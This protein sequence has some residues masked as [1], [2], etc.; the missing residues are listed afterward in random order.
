M[1]RR[2]FT[3][4]L[5]LALLSLA[6]LTACTDMPD[7]LKIGVAQPLS[8]NMAPH[9]N[10]LLNGVK[11]AVQELNAEGFKVKGK[12]IKLEI[13]PVDDRSSPEAGKEVAKQL[14]DAGVVAV[15]GHL[16][17]GVS[18][19][20]APIY[21]AKGIPQLAISTNPKYTE[22][23]I[24][25]AFR[26]VANDK[27]QAKAIGSFAISRMGGTRFAVVDDGSTYGKDLAAG[28]AAQLV[29]GKKNI[30]FQESFDDKTV[31]FDSL[32]QHLKEVRVDALI[33]T[34]NDFQVLALL[35]SLKKIGHTQ[36]SIMGGDLLKT[37]AM[38]KAGND[39]LGIYVSSPIVQ[40]SEF[41]TGKVFLAK[42]R[43]AFKTEP[44][45]AGHYTYDAMY[46]IAAAIKKAESAKPADIAAALRQIDSYAPITG[47]LSFDANG[48]QKYGAISIYQLRAE[49]WELQLRSDVW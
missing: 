29:A 38:L 14:V 35:E 49:K 3:N 19:P 28:A 8:G 12:T 10:D 1:N 6:G 45:Y 46:A 2:N 31:A 30:I 47:S 27:L 23:G 20:T 4:S 13:V 25:T 39:F 18:I 36:L 34:L 22:L 15:I 48:D 7:T 11:L 16:N 41:A 37:T 24:P 40:A 9:G 33:A 32:A 5:P 17:S 26:L 44:V 42:Y 43:A 21:A